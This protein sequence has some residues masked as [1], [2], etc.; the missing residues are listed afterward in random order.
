MLYFLG[1]IHGNVNVVLRMI[2]LMS[3]G[4]VVIQVGDCGIN[5]PSSAR[6]TQPEV[7]SMLCQAKGVK[8]YYIGGN[9]EYWPFLDKI[10]DEKEPVQVAP[11]VFFCPNGSTLQTHGKTIGFL[12][13]AAS[14]DY[15]F[16]RLG[17][18]WWTS[19]NITKSEIDRAE[20]W[21]GVDLMVTHTPP[22]RMTDKVFGGPLDLLNR[23]SSFGVGAD[24]VDENAKVVERIWKIHNNPTLV[25]G[26][27][28]KT[29]VYETC[30]SLSINELITLEEL[31]NDIKPH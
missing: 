27:I 1:D 12:G 14:I 18:D 29:Y 8:F 25:C 16:R 20:A 10:R 6:T 9:H 5:Y 7:L 4:D 23:M 22:L 26:H 19:E 30:R 11:S 24:W 28:H 2:D 21:K 15:K 31:D 13:G 3:A 17:Y